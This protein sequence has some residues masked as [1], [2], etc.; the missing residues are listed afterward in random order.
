[1]E[2]PVLNERVMGVQGACAIGSKT[3]R[4]NEKLETATATCN[5]DHNAVYPSQSSSVAKSCN[6]HEFG[7]KI[8]QQLS[9]EVSLLA[10]S[11]FK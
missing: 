2:K 6:I 8:T 1:M 11:K 3:E 4:L 9:A 5:K 7:N 10:D